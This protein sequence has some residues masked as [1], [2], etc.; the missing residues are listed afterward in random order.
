MKNVNNT[1]NVSNN[2]MRD[3]INNNIDKSNNYNELN[4]FINIYN[5]REK[6]RRNTTRPSLKERVGKRI[7][8][9]GIIL[10]ETYIRNNNK[11]TTLINIHEGDRYIS[12][13]INIDFTGYNFIN[14]E[15][16]IVEVYGEVYEYKSGNQI[17]YSLNIL[18]SPRYLNDIISPKHCFRFINQSFTHVANKLM[19]EDRIR[20]FEILERFRKIIN[21]YT[22]VDL[23]ED[24]LFNYIVNQY[25]L[26]T[27][28][29]ELHNKNI[30]PDILTL[31]NDTLA[32]LI[33]LCA[34]VVGLMNSIDGECTITNMICFIGTLCNMSQH[35][36][37]YNNS[38]EEFDKFAISIGL[39]KGKAWR[40]V[41]NR[42][43][44]NCP[45]YIDNIINKGTDVI[46]YFVYETDFSLYEKYDIDKIEI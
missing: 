18:E 16:S 44:I 6:K 27:L 32:N 15:S 9:R 25:M 1:N 39:K 37:N 26:N 14:K 23:G 11:L 31:R 45:L 22:S 20:K 28:T 2:N 7:R 10:K 35:I 21:Y 24:F 5:D 29:N 12:D 17:K 4:Y 38:T 43:L 13:H 41:K 8:I 33:N 42:E 3:I 19:N 30:N 34:H 46:W 40:I 36:I